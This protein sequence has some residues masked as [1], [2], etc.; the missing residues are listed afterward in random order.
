MSLRTVA[1]LSL[2]GAALALGLCGCGRSSADDAISPRIEIPSSASPRD[3]AVLDVA[4]FGEVR[5]ELLNDLAPK[6]A[7]HFERLAESHYYDGTTFH[8]VVPGVLAQGGDPNTRDRDPR[9]DGAGGDEERVADERPA[10]SHV[11]GVVSLANRGWPN[12]GG[13]QFFI[14]AGDALHL[15]GNFAAFGRVTAG[16]DVVDRIAAAERDVYGRY[17]PIDRPLTNVVL[18]QVRIERAEPASL[19]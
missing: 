3:V 12:S 13:A 10:V 1:I 18:R 4:G 5:V 16:L 6:T 9:N 14:L 19:P 11:R 2:A 15:D 7:A 17:G 8:R